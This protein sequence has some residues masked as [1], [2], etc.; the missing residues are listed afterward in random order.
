MRYCDK[1]DISVDTANLTETVYRANGLYDPQYAT[2][3]G[4]PLFR[5]QFAALY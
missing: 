5:D 1:I 3:G 2:G 4:Q